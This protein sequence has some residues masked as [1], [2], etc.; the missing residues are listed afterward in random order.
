MAR[1]AETWQPVKRVNQISRQGKLLL[2]NCE[3]DVEPNRRLRDAG[4]MG[5]ALLSA[6]ENDHGIAHISRADEKVVGSIARK[7]SLAPGESHIATFAIVW[8]FPNLS[9]KGL[10]TPAGRHYATRFDAATAVAS[11]LAAHFDRLY[12]QTK[13]WHDAWYD[14]TLPHWLLQRTLLNAS[15]LATSTA[16]RFSDGRF[17]GNE[18]VIDAPGTCTHVWHYEQAMGRLFPELDILLRERVDF[19]PQIS[20]KADGLID[21]RGEFNAGEAVDGQAGIILRALRDHQTSPD[22]SFLKRNWSAIKKATQWL[23]D[24][25]GD[26]DGIL[27]GA[28]HNTLDAEW[29]GAVAWLSGLYLAAL[30]AAEEM[31]LDCGDAL[32]AQRCRQI[33]ET[34]QRNFVRRL[35]NGEYFVNEID[36][37]HLQSINSGNGCE[38][39][40]VL[41]QSWAFQVALGRIFP[42]AE[43]RSA[44]TAL[45]RYNFVPDIGPY[46]ASNRPGRW[47][48]MPGEAG[49]LMCTFPRPDGNSIKAKEAQSPYETGY[50]NECMTGFEHLVAAHMIWEGMVKEGLAIERA[51][52]DRYDSFFRNPWNEVEY[53]DHYARAM[54]SYGVFIAACGFEYHG[55]KGH[56]AFSPRLTPENF[57]SAFTASQGWGSFH[58]TVARNGMTAAINLRWGTLRLRTL[59]LTCAGDVPPTKVGVL[60]NNKVVPAHVSFVGSR[61]A[62][63]LSTEV[64]LK[65]GERLVVTLS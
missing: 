60:V 53:G 39:D 31:A 12:E 51:V 55:P 33:F 54:A 14:S 20:F 8:C 47:F 9:I 45:W 5:L 38:I 16:M 28:Q 63:N 62:I 46:R 64:R 58:Q 65:Q 1:T 7:F 59:A 13:A 43:T 23:I 22:D 27:E 40:Q 17:Y 2:L 36:P 61:A 21:N 56:I 42:E 3:S 29:Y 19:N 18:G 32:F 34:G 37:H 49:L 15:T 24:Q 35:F 11:Y 50:F 4:T 41:G 30:R 52:H 25:D 26:A 6:T 10:K 48:A 57:R 44:L